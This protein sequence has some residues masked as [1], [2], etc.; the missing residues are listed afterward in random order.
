MSF[1][2]S[3]M[4]TKEWTIAILDELIKHPDV[5]NET[6]DSKDSGLAEAG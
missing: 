5:E 6:L 3:P 4:N 1:P 2:A